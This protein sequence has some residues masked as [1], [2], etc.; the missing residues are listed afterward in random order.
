M[1]DVVPCRIRSRR[2]CQSRNLIRA[3]LL[4]VPLTISA[5]GCGTNPYRD[6]ATNPY[7]YETPEQRADYWKTFIGLVAAGLAV[8]AL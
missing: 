1:N 7:Y 6:P 2:A 5:T 8:G 3:I 4:T